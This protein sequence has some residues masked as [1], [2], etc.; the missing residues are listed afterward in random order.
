[1]MTE[2]ERPAAGRKRSSAARAAILE[3]AL[4]LLRERSYA[5]LSCEAIAAEARVGK[6]TIY[7]WWNNKADVVLEALSEHARAVTAPETGNLAG[8]V[9]A[10]FESTFRL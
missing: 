4:A 10:F 2:T 3:A 6:Q 7:R 5:E 8:D 9:C 1:M